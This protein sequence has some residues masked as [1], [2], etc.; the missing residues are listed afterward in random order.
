MS[1]RK[2]SFVQDEYYHLYNR[3]VEKRIIFQDKQDYE[4][5]LSLVYL[6]NSKRSITL[7]DIGKNFDRGNPF[8]S[9]GAYC[10]MPNHF[11]ILLKQRE[12]GGISTYMRKVLTGYASYFNKKNKR[13]GTLF[14]NVFKSSHIDN[15]TY[16][17]YSYAYI[18]L[19]PAKLIDK[20]WKNKKVKNKS[21]L[22]RNVLSYQ[23]SSLQEYTQEKYT[24]L[25]PGDFPN[26][27]KT[28]EDQKKD[29]FIW[30]SYAEKITP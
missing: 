2:I 3:G 23:Y 7:R 15:D 1:E 8:V 28:L 29:L 10:L 12:E 24:I 26:Y 4:H 21:L 6:C 16:L 9:I 5:F 27:F 18:H 19:N 25:N 22:L 13:T 30:L 17:R 14:E 20:D 11:H